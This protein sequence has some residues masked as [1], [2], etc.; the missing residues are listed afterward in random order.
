MRQSGLVVARQQNN[1]D[2]SD[3]NDQNNDQIVTN[4]DNFQ[5]KKKVCVNE[6]A[7]WLYFSLFLRNA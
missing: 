1:S 6:I 2:F 7:H 4:R 5:T 3:Y